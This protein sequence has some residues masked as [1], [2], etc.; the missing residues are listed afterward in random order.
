MTVYT[1]TTPSPV[2]YNMTEGVVHDTSG[3]TTSYNDSTVTEQEMVGEKVPEVGAGNST[4]GDLHP[5]TKSWF[6]PN[7]SYRATL[8]TLDANT[9]LALDEIT[10]ELPGKN[11]N[12]FLYNIVGNL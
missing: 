2:N 1:T 6:A 12:L 10:I 4:F 3:Y 8:T 11:K 9:G 5:F 7:T